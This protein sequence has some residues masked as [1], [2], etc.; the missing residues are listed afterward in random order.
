MI[1]EH[2]GFVAMLEAKLSAHYEDRAG[3]LTTVLC[4]DYADYRE[5]RGYLLGLR[6]L[7]ELIEEI[8]K[9]VSGA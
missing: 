6:K 5:R 9:E 3:A 1:M 2:H 4:P 7:A 8:R